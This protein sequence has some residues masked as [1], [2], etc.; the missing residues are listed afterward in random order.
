MPQELSSD[1][2]IQLEIEKMKIKLNDSQKSLRRDICREL[3][4]IH[5][6]DECLDNFTFKKQRRKNV[7]SL[8]SGRSKK[9]P[10][11]MGNT[12][13]STEEEIRKPKRNKKY[14]NSVL[15]HAKLFKEFHQS[16]ANQIKKINR[17]LLNYHSSKARKELQIKERAEKERLK[18]LKVIFLPPFRF[19]SF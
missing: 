4:W 15:L 16:H 14:L 2:K 10:F 3:N 9:S 11:E 18:A 12:H 17:S 8:A 7:E 13:K 6:M 5:G 19:P 1:L